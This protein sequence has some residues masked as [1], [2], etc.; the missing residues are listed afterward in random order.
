MQT[1]SEL[2]SSRRRMMT[3]VFLLQADVSA[4]TSV[5]QLVYIFIHFLCGISKTSCALDV[6]CEAAER[7]N[8]PLK[9]ALC[10]SKEEK[11]KLK[12]NQIWLLSKYLKSPVP[13]MRTHFFCFPFCCLCVPPLG[14]CRQIAAGSFG[15][16][17]YRVPE[18]SSK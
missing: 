11:R 10:F 8:C 18:K 13:L 1:V 6:R 2:L 12:K 15:R 7:Q 17:F 4:V 16:F 9:T 3:A 5:Y 14:D